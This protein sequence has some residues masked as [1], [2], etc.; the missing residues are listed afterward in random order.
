VCKATINRSRGSP[1]TGRRLHF[2]ARR[3]NRIF[4]V[5]AAIVTRTVLAALTLEHE[6]EAIALRIFD[7]VARGRRF[8]EMSI[9][10]AAREPYAS[11]L[12]TNLA[13]FGIPARFHF[14]NSL[15]DHPVIRCLMNAETLDQVRSLRSRVELSDDE[16]IR[17]STIGALGA[18]DSVVECSETLAELRSI[19]SAQKFRA[20]DE[21]HNVV[22]VVDVREAGASAIVF[23]CGVTYQQYNDRK[24]LDRA[25]SLATEEIIFSYPRFND[26]GDAQ[27]R[28][29]FLEEAGEQLPNIRAFPEPV[30][31]APQLAAHQAIDT[32]RSVLSPTAI[33]SFLQ[34]PFQFFARKTLRLEPAPE[35]SRERLNTLVQGII[36]HRAIAEG[37]F[38]GA[39]EDECRKHDVPLG[40]RTEAIRLELLRHFEAFQADR[41]WALK[42]PAKAE[43]EF[44]IELGPRV[45]VRGR[46]DLLLMGPNNEAIVID[47]KYSAA[48]KIRER[49]EG[50]PIQAGLYLSAA[51]RFFHLKPAGM[52]Y[53]GLRDKV[54][55]EGW[56]AGV[57]GLR[58]GESCTPSMLR[59]LIQAAEQK[60][61]EVFARIGAGEK[62]VHPADRAK[63]RYCDYNQIC[64]VESIGETVRA[65]S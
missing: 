51:E 43:Q 37:S 58:L 2:R 35:K 59:E 31:W 29:F 55:W 46:I 33:E 52:F 12:E 7:Y 61:I 49:V 53:C 64:R 30:T 36:L 21:R 26:K 8:H 6:A 48:S 60:A 63:C 19:V 34:C 65:T 41:Q 25:V 39:F 18:F 4:G 56:H 20:A 10:L 42:W 24:L 54:T 32:S 9:V 57:P 47:Y 16:E 45:I 14:D 22:N 50:D 11:A 23:V 44:M 15:C 62:D 27:L 13:R 38:E 17:R 5:A 3:I 28:S 1:G 40:Y